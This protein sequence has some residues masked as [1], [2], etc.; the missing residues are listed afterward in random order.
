MD[1]REWREV[2]ITP[3]ATVEC[4]DRSDRPAARQAGA[5]Q[6]FER[7]EPLEGLKRASVLFERLERSWNSPPVLSRLDE[8]YRRAGTTL[9]FDLNGLNEAQRLNGWNDLNCNFFQ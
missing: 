1:G 2:W 7:L 4:F 3:R 8:P 5:I 6:R 9:G